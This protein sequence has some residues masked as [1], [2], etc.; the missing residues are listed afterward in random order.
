[1]IIELESTLM[2]KF[3]NIDI[4]SYSSGNFEELFYLI[5][6]LVNKSFITCS[7]NV[8]NTSIDSEHIH[9]MLK[10][11]QHQNAFGNTLSILLN[12]QDFIVQDIEVSL[13][14]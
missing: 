14:H 3:I 13:L 9:I 11:I 4:H 7:Y 2:K 8:T 5:N 12:I 1:M 6:E 10:D